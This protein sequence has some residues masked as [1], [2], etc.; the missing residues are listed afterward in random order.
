MKGAREEILSGFYER[1]LGGFSAEVR[2]FVE[3]RPLPMTEREIVAL[4]SALTQKGIDAMQANIQP[5]LYAS[6]SANRSG[7]LVRGPDVGQERS[8]PFVHLVPVKAT[9]AVSWKRVIRQR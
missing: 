4:D 7:G 3:D 8:A 1:A 5:S 6:T 2:E 9:R